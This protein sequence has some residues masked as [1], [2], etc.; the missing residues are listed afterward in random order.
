MIPSF[1][2]FVLEF[3]PTIHFGEQWELRA[4]Q[5]EIVSTGGAYVEPHVLRNAVI[6]MLETKLNAIKKRSVSNKRIVRVVNLGDIIIQQND[7]TFLPTFSV[8]SEIPTPIDPEPRKYT[9]S[10]FCAI[11]IANDAITLLLHDRHAPIN[12]IKQAALDHYIR[13]N[14]DEG[15]ADVVHVYLDSKTNI[16]NL[17][18]QFYAAPD[19]QAQPA[20]QSTLEREATIL[21]GT[22]INNKTVR[23]IQQNNDG[24]AF[25]I[26]DDGSMK[27]LTK[28]SKYTLDDGFSGEVTTLGSNTKKEYKNR[29]NLFIKVKGTIPATT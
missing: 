28:G 9:G 26:F 25:I 17:D 15:I 3:K 18:E 11:T 20:Y 8:L 5:L 7:R 10:V 4:K 2:Q 13:M 6:D 27:R 29:P 1:I 22:R 24:S 23:S 12:R 16:I 21:P 14:P 19:R